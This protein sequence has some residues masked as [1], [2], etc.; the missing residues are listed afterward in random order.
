M[1]SSM[2]WMGSAL[3]MQGS[4][5]Q[6]QAWSSGGEGWGAAGGADGWGTVAG[7]ADGWGTFAGACGGQAESWGTAAGGCGGQGDSLG[8]SAGNSSSMGNA[9]CGWT[10][11]PSMVGGCG[12]AQ[13]VSMPQWP[14]AA[15]SNAMLRPS[16]NQA[17]SA[18]LRPSMNQAG[19]GMLGPG[20][21]QAGAAMLGPGMNHAVPKM[22]QHM[23]AQQ[24]NQGGWPSAASTAAVEQEQ[25]QEEEK[26]HRFSGHIRRFFGEKNTGYGFIDC[27][28]TKARYGYDVYI[29]AR[30]MH[31]CEVGDD[32]SFS[33]IR[34][35]KGEPQARN[36]VKA[37]DEERFLAKQAK[38][39]KKQEMALA[40]K[41]SAGVAFAT[42]GPAAPTGLMDEEQAKKFMRSL[43]QRNA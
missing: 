28:E 40:A 14:G 33:I 18:M 16:M 34:N 37:E 42:P 32:V 6:T 10:M 27:A 39:A 7:G 1:A 31:R 35:A 17:G 11:M 20:M 5:S 29:H 19:A 25:P 24:W 12:M 43:K 22:M 3:Q 23:M 13:S 30:Q 36:V 41:R 8:T 38:E 26:E 15:A 9:G 4:E 2:Q 21:N